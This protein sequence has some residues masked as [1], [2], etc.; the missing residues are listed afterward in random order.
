[1]KF[2][3]PY[4]GP[5]EKIDLLAK[6]ILVHSIIYYELN[7]SLVADFNY[8]SNGKQLAQLIKT[9]RMEAIKAKWWYVIKDYEGST[10]FDLINKLSPKHY[11]ELV[12]LANYLVNGGI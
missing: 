3:N 12:G 8:D 10:G 4:W 11:K 5:K 6:W 2:R 7:T 9:N 1:M